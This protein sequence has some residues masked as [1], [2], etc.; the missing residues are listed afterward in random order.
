VSFIFFPFLVFKYFHVFLASSFLLSTCY[1]I[2]VNFFS[3]G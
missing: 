3:F 1:F 2:D